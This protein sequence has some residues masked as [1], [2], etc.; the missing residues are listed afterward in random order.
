MFVLCPHCEFLVGV[1]PR[2]GRPPAACPKCGHAVESTQSE[3]VPAE[4]EA[5]P[6]ASDA[7][8]VEATPEPTPE[9][10]RTQLDPDAVIAAMAAKS[11]KSRAKPRSETHPRAS[12][13]APSRR[14]RAEAPASPVEPPEAAKPT[15]TPARPPPASLA[16]RVA[17]WWSSRAK[18]RTPASPE[19]PAAQPARETKRKAIVRPIRS[20]RDRAAASAAAKQATQMPEIEALSIDEAPTFEPVVAT[21]TVVEPVMAPPAIE[22]ELAVKP[23]ASAAAEPLE[24]P[25]VETPAP[26]ALPPP[27]PHLAPRPST[28]PS[29]LRKRS[30]PATSTAR[31]WQFATLG[32]LALLLA[33]QLLLAQRD[34]LAAN[35]RWRSAI[36]ALCTVTR[37]AVPAWREPD[38]FTMLS[39]DV[40][41]HARAPGA[42]QIDASFRNDARWAQPWPRLVVTLSDIDGR[43]L[44]T[45]AF[46][47]TEYLGSPPTQNTLASG[48]AATV[49]L[50]VVEPAPGVVAFSFDFR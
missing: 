5:A 30:G 39:R 37:C 1:D 47:A 32:G 17:T 8:V 46:T 26:A 18:T 23:L 27:E 38:A 13:K 7:P 35:A 4:V 24:A 11:R 15:E 41:P 2:T 44:G 20:L 43:G 12:E 6:A 19:A 50:V 28:A 42:L 10:A 21:P 36:D 22:P 29:F 3:D 9:P 14:K 16:T 34:A 48:Q 25:P 40:R 45:R 31:W 49:R 33:M